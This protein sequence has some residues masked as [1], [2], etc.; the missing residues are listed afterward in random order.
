MLDQ[1]LGSLPSLMEVECEAKIDGV[2]CQHP[3]RYTVDVEEEGPEAIAV[4]DARHVCAEHLASAADWAFSVPTPYVGEAEDV[5]LTL[6]ER[7]ITI[8]SLTNGGSAGSSVSNAAGG[9]QQG[10]FSIT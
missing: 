4:I 3:A 9:Y 2:P 10:A 5:Y 7:R 1:D 8:A 6:H